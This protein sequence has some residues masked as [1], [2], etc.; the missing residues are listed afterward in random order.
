MTSYSNIRIKIRLTI[1]E[2]TTQDFVRYLSFPDSNTVGELVDE[3]NRR[4]ER[5][6]MI[7]NIYYVFDEQLDNPFTDDTLLGG[8]L[9]PSSLPIIYTMIENG[10]TLFVQATLR[11]QQATPIATA[12]IPQNTMRV[13]GRIY[14]E[15][16]GERLNDMLLN[17]PEGTT[18]GV[19]VNYINN[20]L[21]RQHL[22]GNIYHITSEE[23]YQIS[24]E[25]LLGGTNY[26]PERLIT[27]MG[28]GN[29]S[30]LYMNC[31]ITN[32]IFRNLYIPSVAQLPIVNIDTEGQ[33][34]D[35]NSILDI[36]DALTNIT[37][38]PITQQNALTDAMNSLNSLNSL[39]TLV[40]AISNPMF[41]NVELLN[42]QN[43]NP[44]MEDVVVAL[45]KGDLDKLRVA[46][47]TDFEDRDEND[48]DMCSICFDKFIDSDMCR[49]LKCKHLYHKNCIDKWL[50]EHIT[51]PVCREECGKGVPRL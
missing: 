46:E 49:E 30:M 19:L 34:M 5:D 9:F 24:N 45:D 6:N 40:Q 48:R 27:D 47:Y 35:L 38:Q 16:T 7:G 37:R 28:I 23:G 12:A 43:R 31:R 3:I 29:N 14:I 10:T 51:C 26:Q 50:D 39:N 32:I 2:T 36:Y 22:A 1:N 18:I 21:G 20:E 11:N 8:S 41:T 4:L 15:E 44:R 17:I 33:L 42:T 13:I 25:T